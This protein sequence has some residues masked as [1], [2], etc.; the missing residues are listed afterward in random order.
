MPDAGR[1]E[2]D[3]AEGKLHDR[4]GAESADERPDPDRT[5]EQPADQGRRTEERDA[6]KPDGEAVQALG[7]TDHERVARPAAERSRH[8]GV[9]CIGQY[10]ETRE[11]DGDR[12]QQ[13]LAG[14]H[15]VGPVKEVHRFADDHGV[16]EH[17]DA[18]RLFQQDVDNQDGERHRDGGV[19]VED[20]EGPGK[21]KTEHVPG[22]RADIGLYGQVDPEAVDEQ[23][24]R[25]DEHVQE[26]RAGCAI[27][28]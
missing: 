10:D 19:S 28:A 3:S 24:D 20:T 2:A 21:T 25:R 12:G 4:A 6:D 5:A 16:D 13:R 8:I 22:R 1:V 17:G 7:K 14:C 27:L 26:D 15:E 11:H 18:D 23:A 9:L